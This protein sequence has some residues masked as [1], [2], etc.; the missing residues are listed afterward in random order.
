[1][2]KKQSEGDKGKWNKSPSPAVKDETKNSINIVS[3]IKSYNICYNNLQT[4][5][6]KI[7]ELLKEKEVETEFRSQGNYIAPSMCKSLY[8]FVGQRCKVEGKR[9][10]IFKLYGKKP[11]WIKIK[12][13]KIFILI[14][15]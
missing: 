2:K 15:D 14:C 7:I 13:M 3:S 12:G 4:D 9:Y 11:R 10:G 8:E 6:L 1:M 5:F